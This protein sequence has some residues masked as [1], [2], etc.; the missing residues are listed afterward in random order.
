MVCSVSSC[1]HMALCICALYIWRTKVNHKI[2]YIHN[3]MCRHVRI[4]PFHVVENVMGA[5]A[6]C[7][8]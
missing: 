2:N 5:I 6:N 4:H 7:L 8:I 3:I 1:M